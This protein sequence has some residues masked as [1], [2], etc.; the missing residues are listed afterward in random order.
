ME[1]IISDAKKNKT[2]VADMP[3]DLVVF[4][5]MCWDKACNSSEN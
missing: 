4:T 2:P 3:N 1:L 5:D